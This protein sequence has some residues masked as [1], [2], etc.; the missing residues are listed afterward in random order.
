[1]N[2]LSNLWQ[3]LDRSKRYR[4]SFPAAVVKRMVPLQ[5]RVLR[6]QRGWSQAQLA[7]ESKLT[8]GVIS[9][10]EDP[11]YGN[12]TINTL[13]RIGAG[14]DCAFVGRFVPFSELAKWYVGMT[15]EKSLEV[16][17]FADDRGF[18]TSTAGEISGTSVYVLADLLSSRGW[19]A[20]YSGAENI[21]IFDEAHFAP[22]HTTISCAA[23]TES[24]W[25]EMF[26][27]G[28]QIAFQSTPPPPPPVSIA[29]T[30]VYGGS[31]F[32]AAQ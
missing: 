22:V 28:P 20:E 2:A 27:K 21:R 29:E 26:R 4:E 11:D 15:D 18:I 3:R 6:K 14:F 31:C 1:M 9:R 30:A 12:L 17:S 32:A 13:V 7:Q 25:P 5:I 19:L 24:A 10:A 23:H 16:P 8:Q